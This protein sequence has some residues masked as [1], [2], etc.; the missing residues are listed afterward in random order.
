MTD[1]QVAALLQNGRD[2]SMYPGITPWTLSQT[3]SVANSGSPS[4][5][6]TL[7]PPDG[8]YIFLPADFDLMMK[9]YETGPTEIAATSTVYFGAQRSDRRQPSWPPGEV[10]YR[11]YAALTQAEQILSTN[12]PT[13]RA[14]LGRDIFVPSGDQLVIAVTATVAVDTTISPDTVLYFTAR[15]GPMGT[16]A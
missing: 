3:T 6:W 14:H 5:I 1:A 9:L 11:N 8:H 15:V 10:P 4:T 13:L 12:K 16:L 2:Q 7:Q